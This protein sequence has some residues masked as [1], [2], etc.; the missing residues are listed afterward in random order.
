MPD[1]V[2]HTKRVIVIGGGLT[3]LSAAI[4]LQQQPDIKVTLLEAS[5]KAGGVI[6][7]EWVAGE[8]AHQRYLVENG[9]HTFQPSGKALMALCDDLGLIPLASSSMAKDRYVWWQNK[10]HAVPMSLWAFITTK[11]LTPL[12]KC[13][14][15]AEPFRPKTTP[16]A[17]VAEW[18]N[19][20]LGH[21][22]LTTLV[23]PFLSGVYAGDPDKLI[24]Q[25]VFRRL[26]ALETKSGSVIG[27]AVKKGLTAFS[28]KQSATLKQK[29]RPK[30]SSENHYALMNFTD[31]MATL[32]KVMTETLADVR[33]NMAV[34]HIEKLVDGNWQVHCQNGEKLSADGLCITTP[35]YVTSHMLEALDGEFAK[36]LS[37]VPYDPMVVAHMAFK[38]TAIKRVL[39]GFGFLVPRK[40]NVRL[41]GSIW[42]SS[43]FDNRCPDD[44]VMFTVFIGGATD[45]DAI[46]LND[47]DLKKLIQQEL[48]TI[49]G[50]SPQ[51]QPTLWHVQRW[52]QAIPQYVAGHGDVISGIDNFH[53]I[54]PTCQLAGNFTQGVAMNDCVL[55]GQQA[56]KALIKG[57]V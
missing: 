5:G 56:A 41:L 51:V 57:L 25:H 52:Q 29:Q 45:P 55:N 43:L 13:R 7:S 50:L 19:N 12:G 49:I 15:L 21:E 42:V 36:K 35:T 24:A 3:G 27:G 30:Q 34:G 23:G 18:V 37:S 6:Q 4:A 44:E 31:G 11:L 28:A 10:L 2:V 16:N 33:L 8:E 48:T 53:Q 26:V 54:H 17:T 38:K 46:Y 47:G 20:R 1:T 39:N 32:P 40:I 22:A 9:P 14:L